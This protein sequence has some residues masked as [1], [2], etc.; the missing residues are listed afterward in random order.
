MT[1]AALKPTREE[2]EVLNEYHSAL[3]IYYGAVSNWLKRFD[4]R[5]TQNPKTEPAGTGV[6]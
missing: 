6:L 1:M 2:V 4:I 5:V 3:I